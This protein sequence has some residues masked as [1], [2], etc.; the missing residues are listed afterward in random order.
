MSPRMMKTIKEQLQKKLN[1]VERLASS[2]SEKMFRH[3]YKYI[4]AQFHHKLVYPLTR[5]EIIKETSLFFGVKMAV[6]LPASTDIYLTGGK[7]HP[8]EIRLARYMIQTLNEGDRFLDIG[9]HYGYFSL[10]A[11]QLVGADGRVHAYE[12]SRRA[13]ELLGRNLKLQLNSVVYQAAVSDSTEPVIFYEFP[14]LFSEYNST[15][16]SQFSET[17][18]FRKYKPRETS[19]KSTTIDGLTKDSFQPTFI[20][21]DV[22]GAEDRVINGGM[23]FL[24]DH[25]PVVVMEYLSAERGNEAH[26]KAESLLAR[27]NYYPFAIQDDGELRQI[28]GVEGYL[29]VNRLDSDNIVFKKI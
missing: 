24:T 1:I 20:K 5:K 27:L 18:W 3:P 9:A 12:P 11:A 26:K 23:K 28:M 16:I 25:A 8:S 29:K 13:F 22:E 2:M 4:T 19:V 15:D 7:A 21:I 14:N 17:T 10:L 6:A